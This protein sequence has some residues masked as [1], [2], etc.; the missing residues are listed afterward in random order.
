MEL[1]ANFIRH[2]INKYYAELALYNTKARNVGLNQFTKY[3]L[4]FPTPE[5]QTM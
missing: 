2:S 5:T 3:V 4:Y 1:H